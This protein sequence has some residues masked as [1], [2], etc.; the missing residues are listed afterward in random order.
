MAQVQN[1]ITFNELFSESTNHF[2][3][4]FN[5][6]V[7]PSIHSGMEL[8]FEL[9]QKDRKKK[10]S[11]ILRLARTK[12]AEDV[13][14]VYLDIYGGDYPYKEM[15][16]V[17]KVR[18]MIESDEYKF[19][20]FL[21]RDR[22]VVG[23]FTYQLDFEKHRGYMRGFNIKRQYQ[24]YID[25][26]KACIGS[27]VGMWNEYNED[28]AMWY[29]ENRTAHSKSQYIAQVCGIKPVAF[30]PCKDIFMGKIESDL[31][32]I[33][34][35]KETLR[36]KRSKRIPHILPQVLPCFSYSDKR[37]NLGKVKMESPQLRLDYTEVFRLNYDLIL[38]NQ[39]DKFGYIKYKFTFPKSD[40]YF[41]FLYT[42][43]VNNF[44]KVKYHVDSLEEFQVFTS[45][46]TQLAI[47]LDVRY[48]EIF[49]SAYNSSHQ[50]IIL[51]DGFKP[52]GYVPSWE[53]NHLT[54]EYEDHIVF[55][56]FKGEI[57]QK[58]KLIEEGEDLIYHLNLAI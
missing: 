19:L 33:V 10:I 2:L 4:P 17:E 24:G 21:D 49:I 13:V 36:E 42:P 3:T 8:T 29:C 22:T 27:M 16:D 1:V 12:D 53:Y 14:S 31:M 30:F 39:E 50:K 34:Y 48:C 32:Q 20:M 58:L 15:E 25:A 18:K 46:F 23:C 51:D 5:E 7:K 35:N 56:S 47:D 38:S 44:E 9:T 52:R 41:S 6:I 11:P 43:N 55:N 57:D 40:S 26:V 54:D 45:R 37:Y 28:I